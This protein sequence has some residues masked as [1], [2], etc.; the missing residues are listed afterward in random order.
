MFGYIYLT[1]NLINNMK[2]VGQK[3]S[4]E[5]IGNAYLGSGKIL[6]RAIEKYGKENFTVI[7]LEEV[8]GT[9]DNLNERE[10]YWIKKLNAV[11]SSEF[12]NLHPG[13][14]GGA[15]YGHKGH[16]LSDEQRTKMSNMLKKLYEDN[17]EKRQN[18]SN[19]AI[20]RFSDPQQRQQISDSMTDIW[21][22]PEYRAHQSEVHKGHPSG[23]KNKH[24]TESAKQ[25]ISQKSKGRPSPRKGVKL[26]KEQRDLH[27]KNIKGR[28]FWNNGVITVSTRECP[29]EGWVR[30]RLN[31]KSPER[32]AITGRFIKKER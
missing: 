28:H 4:S 2:Y 8:D 22:D 10:I 11:D 19:N 21:K 5:F 3:T 7:L 29:G 6:Q 12:Y 31:F 26:S 17:P 1:T 25:L 30:G 14:V 20:Q 15:T 24:H 16:R 27:S 18:A 23:M 9:K 13:G 32:D